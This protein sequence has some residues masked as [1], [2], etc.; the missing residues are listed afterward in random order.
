MARRLIG[1]GAAFPYD[2]GM[3][4]A[5]KNLGGIAELMRKAGEMQSRM[6]QLQDDLARKT[7][8]A[9]AGAGAVSAVVNGRLELV[10][11]RIDRTR[12]DPND[13]ELVEDL[14][15]AAVSAAQAKARDLVQQEMARLTQEL[16]L[17][18]GMLPPG[19][20]GST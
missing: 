14:V 12:V 17:P 3:F 18:A 9:D 10:S 2:P 19:L 6:K 1:P 8:S 5:L 15:V 13:T 16:G 11:V 4:D 20:P 7:V